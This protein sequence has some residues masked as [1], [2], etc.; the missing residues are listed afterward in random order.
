MVGPKGCGK[1]TLIRSLVRHYTKQSIKRCRGPITVVSGKKRR[2]TLFEC[3]ND[4]NA[5]CD[6][7]KVADLVLLMIDAS[8]GF[9]METFEFLNILKTHGFPKVMGVLT[10]LD[11]IKTTKAVAKT[12]K[13][14]KHRFWTEV[15]DGAKLFYLSGAVHGR[16]LKREILNLARFI[17]VTKFHPLLWRNTH[18]YILAD[19]FEDI[20][21]PALVASDP[22]CDRTLSFYG[23]VRG[24]FMKPRQAVHFVGVDDL[25]LEDFEL[26]EDPVPLAS[27]GD[28]S[29]PRTLKEKD[30]VLYAPMADVGDISY[31]RDAVYITMKGRNI[32]FSD[33]K[34]ILVDPTSS[35]RS[36]GG[37]DSDEDDAETMADVQ[38]SSI[39]E[40][41]EPLTAKQEAALAVRRSLDQASGEG[42]EM[43]R[44]LQQLSTPVEDRL[45]SQTG[46]QLLKGIRLQSDPR[47]DWSD[48]GTEEP[49]D[50]LDDRI[51]G[52]V[53]DDD[54]AKNGTSPEDI[55]DR[56]RVVE[57]KTADGR[58]RRRVVFM[59]EVPKSDA[60]RHDESG[61][62]DDEDE[63]VTMA[64]DGSED[65][66][67]GEDEGSG[68]ELE[69][70]WSSSDSDEYQDLPLRSS[71][72]RSDTGRTAVQMS[73]AE[74]SALRWKENLVARASEQHTS[75]SGIMELVYGRQATP[76]S[77]LLESVRS[78]STAASS[79]YSTSPDDI[80]DE[81][82]ELFRLK[83]PGQ[84]SQ[85]TQKGQTA[86]SPSGGRDTL[87][88]VDSE[89]EGVEDS[90]K[91]ARPWQYC[92]KPWVAD[93]S[94][95]N[96]LKSSAFVTG[97]WTEEDTVD[98]RTQGSSGATAGGDSGVNGERGAEE[99][100]GDEEDEISDSDVYGSDMR[101]LRP[102]DIT[103]E[104]LRSLGSKLS[105]EEEQERLKAAKLRT[106]ENFDRQ[107]DHHSM[108]GESLAR[109]EHTRAE[110][111]EAEE[112]S[113]SEEDYSRRIQEEVERKQALNETAF[114]DL[115]PAER[116][117]LQGA[118]A[119]TYVRVVARGIPAEFVAHFDHSFPVILGGLQAHEHR[120][121][122]VRTRLKRHRWFKKIL[123][124]ND[125]F[126]VSL[127]WRRFQTMPVYAI[128]DPNGRNRFLKYTPEHMHCLATFYG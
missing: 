10:H 7:A 50:T 114:Q 58:I 30:R 9:E 11:K 38:L 72:R 41:G 107:Y 97:D 33:P 52:D 86:V 65:D 91:G 79:P 98:L 128:E 93:E 23:Y 117:R 110:F 62:Q 56:M 4:L 6:V 68:D 27:A 77:S 101:R 81:V 102:S 124:T 73:G 59:D 24:T 32:T 99:D 60:D 113:D 63:D 31:D 40:D 18:P 13:R 88:G 12:K 118:P 1:S 45:R 76:E 94:L 104:G 116:V 106:K 69:D 121:G 37:H 36:P 35:S 66:E 8:F 125:P 15:V 34:D 127:G 39:G 87:L 26:V 89:D 53:S 96:R 75:L 5:M 54:A 16:Y 49:S 51:E 92:L 122:L 29:K 43:V 109:V 83:K 2:I 70:D 105:P 61:D 25:Q 20:T 74:A 67:D 78:Q 100:D 119:G 44:R 111:K 95:R 82:E 57:E 19:R 17:S 71:P 46:F 42:Q 14:L 22:S 21:D 85:A 48:D 3:P 123:K 64:S 28:K 47:N 55:F 112:G 80:D 108:A 84:G 120:L 90:C 115:T 103:V 126:I